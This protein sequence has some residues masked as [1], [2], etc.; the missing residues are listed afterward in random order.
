MA[1]RKP[2][3]TAPATSSPVKSA[4]V[5]KT[6]SSNAT[7]AVKNPSVTATPPKDTYRVKSYEDGMLNLEQTPE[8]LVDM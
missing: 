1:P 8:H 7:S 5:I 6:R 3:A 2:K 4:R